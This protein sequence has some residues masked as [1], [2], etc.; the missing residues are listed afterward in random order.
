M[1]TALDV[2]TSAR[3]NVLDEASTQYSDPMMLDFLNRGLKP[4]CTALAAIRSDWVNAYTTLTLAL[5]DSTVALPDLF[6]S[7]IKCTIGTSDL[8]KQSVSYIRAALRTSTSGQPSYYAIQGANIAFE[9]VV[10]VD[11]SILLEYNTSVTPLATTASTMPFNGEF[12]DLL[13]QF[14]TICAKTRNKYD[15][16]SDTGIYSFFYS[17]VLDKVVSRTYIPNTNNTDF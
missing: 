7:P 8:T 5:G 11:T 2:I 12:D 3:Y 15:T 16:V 13:A 10:L 17:A 14:V 6:I 4:L 9:R 1:S